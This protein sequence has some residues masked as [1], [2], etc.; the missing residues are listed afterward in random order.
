MI[1]GTSQADCGVL[2]IAAGTGL[3]GSSNHVLDEISVAR[4]VNDGD[5]ELGSFKLPQSDVNGDTTLAFGLKF[6]QNP[7]VLEGALAHLLGL[8]F[9][10]LDGTFVDATAFVDQVT[11]GG[12]LARVY[13]ANNHNVNMGLLLGHVGFLV[14]QLTL[15]KSRP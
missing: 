10:L 5:I 3:R 14:K 13:V 15:S 11:S 2:I 8:L 4:G 9:E 1:T 12:R 7:S 6:V